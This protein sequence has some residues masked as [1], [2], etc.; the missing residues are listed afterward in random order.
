MY[1]FAIGLA[2]L[3]TSCS[4]DDNSQQVVV[5]ENTLEVQATKTTIVV[6]ESI[7]FTTTLDGKRE[8]E[9]E[10]YIGD[11]R[12]YTPHVFSTVGVFEVIAKKGGAKSSKPVII[13][14]EK[15]PGEEGEQIK[16]LAIIANY[17]TVNVGDVVKFSITDGENKVADAII[18]D[19]EGKVVANGAWTASKEGTFKFS[20]SKEGYNNSAEIEVN[21]IAKNETAEYFIEVNGDAHEIDPTSV[22]MLVEYEMVDGV[23]KPKIFSVKTGFATIHYAN[24]VI[25]A[26]TTDFGRFGGEAR[27]AMM[28][29]TKRVLQDIKK[30][31]QLPGENPDR[32]L[33]IGGWV[34][35]DTKFYDIKEEHF[36]TFDTK[37]KGFNDGGDTK[38]LIETPSI[39]IS[40]T[41]DF[42][43]MEFTAPSK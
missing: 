39:K 41:G 21:V 13:T 9:A 10:L 24:F 28:R 36:K 18:K 31:L 1:L 22:K 32:E 15:A 2:V 27:G 26:T 34:S 8:K 38:I 14:V 17:T 23:K 25:S 12:I 7:R 20:A 37:L 40:Y 6:N 19:A 3:G 43:S 5:L 42:R 30:P 35:K 29:I 4:S 33:N 16:T 11:Q